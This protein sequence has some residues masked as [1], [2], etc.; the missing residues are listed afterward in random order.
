MSLIST[1]SLF[2]TF[3]DYDGT[4]LQTGTVQ[5]GSSAI[6][7]MNPMR[8]GYTFSG[9]NPS[10]L[11]NITGDKVFTGAYVI[12]RYTLSFEENGGSSISDQTEIAYNTTGINPS[13]PTKTGY[14]FSGWYMS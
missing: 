3:V 5:Y 6:A 13:I 11:S 14:V 10:G 7:P 1:P 9:W 4:L 12:N 2:V 8:T